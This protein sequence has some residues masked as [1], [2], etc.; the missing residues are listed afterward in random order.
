MC[1][2]DPRCTAASFS[3][4]GINGPGGMVPTHCFLFD[5]D[6]AGWAGDITTKGCD[7]KDTCY[8]KQKCTPK[9]RYEVI[10]SNDPDVQ[11]CT[12]IMVIKICPAA[13]PNLN[14]IMR[15]FYNSHERCGVLHPGI[16]WAKHSCQ[17][18]VIGN[19][20]TAVW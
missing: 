11:R 10:T 12:D 15:V 13:T 8:I 2:K 3:H 6:T 1:E 7:S 19:S 18:R 4:N 17:H 5:V 20:S 16:D 9:Y 14:S